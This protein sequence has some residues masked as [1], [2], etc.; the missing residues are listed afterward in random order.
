MKIAITTTGN[1]ID[2]DVDSRFGRCINFLIID[3]DSTLVEVVENKSTQS[4]HGAG[5]GAAQNV[6]SMKVEALITGHVGPNAFMAL[7]KAG[8]KIYT[9]ANGTVKDALTQ[10]EEGKLKKA[11]NPSVSGHHGQGKMIRV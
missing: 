10:Y 4:A 2:S 8:I 6:V 11:T 9:G 5:I 3:T 1:D 7:S